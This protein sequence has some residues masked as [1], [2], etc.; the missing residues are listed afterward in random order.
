[1]W[2]MAIKDQ[3]PA[4]LCGPLNLM[5]AE[6]LVGFIQLWTLT[7]SPPFRLW[8]QERTPASPLSLRRSKAL[9]S[10]RETLNWSRGPKLWEAGCEYTV[11]ASSPNFYDHDHSVGALLCP[12]LSLQ[13]A[14]FFLSAQVCS[15]GADSDGERLRQRPGHR[16]GGEA[17]THL[18]LHQSAASIQYRQCDHMK[19]FMVIFSKSMIQ[20]IYFYI[21][22]WI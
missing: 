5:S 3:T 19:Y 21:N 12:Q 4:A 16:G 9:P 18:C 13:C 22:L 2:Q 8:N 1:M 20:F 10:S 11:T 6:V 7:S 14:V 15:E 17:P